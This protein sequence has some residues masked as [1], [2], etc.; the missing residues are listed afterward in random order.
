MDEFDGS[1]IL[2]KQSQITQKLGNS[3]NFEIDI[4]TI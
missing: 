4:S 1:I 3:S 2:G